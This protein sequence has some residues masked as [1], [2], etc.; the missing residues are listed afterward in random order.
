MENIKQMFINIG[1]SDI[2]EASEN[3]LSSGIIDSIDVMALIAEIEKFYKK[4]LNAKFIK[5]ENF[6]NINSIK[7]MVSEAIK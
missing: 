1:R 3:L 6:E 7:N 5:A 2:D 4:P